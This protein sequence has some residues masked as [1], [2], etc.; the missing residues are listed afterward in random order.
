MSAELILREASVVRSRGIARD[1][2]SRIEA[3]VLVLM[4]AAEAIDRQAGGE[5]GREGRRVK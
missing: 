3:I 4:Y 1:R 2:R 5:G